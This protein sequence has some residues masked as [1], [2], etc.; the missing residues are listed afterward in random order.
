VCASEGG[1]EMTTLANASLACAT[2]LLL[3]ACAGANYRPLIDSQGVDMSRFE[4]DLRDCQGYAEGVSGA[5]T[6]AAVGAVA[7]A[8]FGGLLAA[9]AGRG[10]DQG[11]TARVGAVTGAVV[12]GAGGETSQQDVVRRCVAGRGYRVLQ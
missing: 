4:A 1:S 12:G 7:G 10:Y 2:S 11:A 3:V 8:L 6:Q 5:G 9:V